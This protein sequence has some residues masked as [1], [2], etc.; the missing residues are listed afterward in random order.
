MV[1]ISLKPFKKLYEALI[2]Q[3]SSR[4]PDVLDKGEFSGIEDG[5]DALI[6]EMEFLGAA[7]STPGDL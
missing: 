7:R 4:R 5:A 1:T 3:V 6:I 2:Y